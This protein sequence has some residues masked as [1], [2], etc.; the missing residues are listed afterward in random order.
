M[1]TYLTFIAGT[2]ATVGLRPCMMKSHESGFSV[3]F[4]KARPMSANRSSGGEGG[5]MWIGFRQPELS[6]NPRIHD[7]GSWLS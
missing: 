5:T 4:G 2:L 3:K 7:D 6:L 1:Q